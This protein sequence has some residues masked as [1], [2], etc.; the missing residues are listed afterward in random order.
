MLEMRC[1]WSLRVPVDSRV[2]SRVKTERGRERVEVSN[3]HLHSTFSHTR[4]GHGH[5]DCYI[6]IAL[7]AQEKIVH[8]PIGDTGP[9]SGPTSHTMYRSSHPRHSNHLP[10]YSFLQHFNR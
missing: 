10:H 7:A 1:C 9:N 8:C 6:P 4:S 2:K 3:P 5:E